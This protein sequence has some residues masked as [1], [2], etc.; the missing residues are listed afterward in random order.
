[1]SSTQRSFRR[2][3]AASRVLGALVLGVASSVAALGIATAIQACGSEAQTSGRR[4]ALSTT[5]ELDASDASGFQTAVGWNVTLSKV[6]LA[7][8]AL[9]YF[10]GAPPLVRLD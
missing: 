5:V 9:Y 6:L 1:M 8:G 10:D 7:T 4:V 3:H 2:G